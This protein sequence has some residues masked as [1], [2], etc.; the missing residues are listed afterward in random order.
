MAGL[1]VETQRRIA[2]VVKAM[3]SGSR[4]AFSKVVQD[5]KEYSVG[6]MQKWERKA[7][8]EEKWSKMGGDG[9]IDKTVHGRQQLLGMK[10]KNQERE[11]KRFE[12]AKAM[13]LD[14]KNPNQARRNKARAEAIDK[15]RDDPLG[16]GLQGQGIGRA[17]KHGKI[18]LRSKEVAAAFA[19]S[20]KEKQDVQLHKMFKRAKK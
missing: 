14:A 4:E 11:M 6:K 17:N 9:K 1:S 10:F 18:K 8:E 19:R 15:R 20:K 7:Y 12:N 3:G 2:S 5:V 16:R 13:G